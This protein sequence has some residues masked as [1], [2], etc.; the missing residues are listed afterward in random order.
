MLGKFT[1]E[2]EIE[3]KILLLFLDKF[4]TRHAYIIHHIYKI[5]RQ[6]DKSCWNTGLR[7]VTEV[8]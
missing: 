3:G 1:L 5:S 7:T 8:G 2:T 6:T 4:P